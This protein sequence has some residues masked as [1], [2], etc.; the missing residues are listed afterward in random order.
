MQSRL[1]VSICS[2]RLPFKVRSRLVFR[3][4]QTYIHDLSR[5]AYGVMSYADGVRVWRFEPARKLSYFQCH[6]L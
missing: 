1:L 5:G 2:I 6:D 4:L 3:G